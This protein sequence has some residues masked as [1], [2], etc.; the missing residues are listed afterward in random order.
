MTRAAWAAGVRAVLFDLDGTLADTAPDLSGALNRL[1]TELGLLPISTEITRP[2]TSSGARGMI[3]AGL[4]VTPDHPDYDSLRMRFL[5]LYERHICVETRLF[6]GMAEL[7]SELERLR[8]TWGVVTNK[9]TRFTRPLIDALE[10]STRAACV[11]SGDTTPHSKPH[12]APLLHAALEIGLPPST[13]LYVGDD[14]RDVQAARA[15]GMPVVA[16]AFG[17]LGES[18]PHAWNA[19]AV[20]DGPLELL[21]YLPERIG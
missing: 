13:C 18:D 21:G 14:L 4:G 19:N 10:L 7:L 15:A 2:H 8:L 17:Y 16:A 9:S 3:G 5:D 6:P 1:R 11:V 20:I 12:P